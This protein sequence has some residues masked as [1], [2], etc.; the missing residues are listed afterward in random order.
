MVYITMG[1]QT[2]KEKFLS[3][4]SR[5][6]L[7][8]FHGSNYTD[9]PWNSISYS[10]CR[11][12]K[13]RNANLDKTKHWA[14]GLCRS[15]YR[16]VNLTHRLYNDSKDSTGLKKDYKNCKPSEIVF[17]S[18]DIETVLERYNFQCAY[19]KTFLQNYDHAKKNAFQLEYI[20]IGKRL[21]LV[22]ICRSCNCS[23]KNLPN[24]KLKS[25]AE[26]R[27][28]TYPFKLIPVSSYLLKTN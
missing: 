20:M 3:N 26:A 1:Q 9:L 15:C 8:K 27:E 4:V 14:N 18:L 16:R 17:N 5:D 28:I 21:T 12:C 19:C 24:N 2:S 22:P 11:L 25:W 23:K 10:C 6:L 13:T 7:V